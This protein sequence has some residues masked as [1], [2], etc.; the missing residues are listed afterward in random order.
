MSADMNRSMDL[1][2]TGSIEHKTRETN[3]A[4]IR[5]LKAVAENPLLDSVTKAEYQAAL[6]DATAAGRI[7]PQGYSLLAASQ[8]AIG[9]EGLF[10]IRRKN[11][12]LAKLLLE[13]PGSKQTLL[14]IN[15]PNQPGSVT[16]TNLLGS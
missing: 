13:K 8:G 7:T 4:D 16:Q 9:G 3:A 6:K 14:S 1:T 5:R 11:E 10:G 2:G 12:E 15:T